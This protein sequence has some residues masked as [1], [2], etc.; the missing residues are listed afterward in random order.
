MVNSGVEVFA[1]GLRY[2]L[3]NPVSI[4]FVGYS[5]MHFFFFVFTICIHVVTLKFKVVREFQIPM[6]KFKKKKC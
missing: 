3:Q 2:F 6:S 4:P 5:E 1:V